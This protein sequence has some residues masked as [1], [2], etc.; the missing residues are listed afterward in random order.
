MGG[1]GSYDPYRPDP[2]GPPGEP[3]PGCLDLQFTA[4]VQMPA[5][6]VEVERNAVL[7]VAR[8]SVG[9]GAM[10]VGVL[11]ADGSLVGSII[12]ELE[13]LL[14]CLSRGIAFIGDVIVVNYGVPS[15]RVSA[16]SIPRVEGTATLL[17]VSGAPSSPAGPIVLRLDGEAAESP[18][19]KVVAATADD[20]VIGEVEHL[21]QAELRALIRVGVEFGI[22]MGD[23]GRVTISHRQQ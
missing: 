3:E 19:G 15:I 6:P 8:T 7:E 10:I 20:G 2:G 22:E 11:D 4:T 14:P 23:D 5:E 1:T 9:D 17:R 18:A 13:R 12:D 21:R 16:A